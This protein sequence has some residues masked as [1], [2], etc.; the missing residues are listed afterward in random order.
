M[1]L[2]DFIKENN[3]DYSY[4]RVSESFIDELE[5]IVGFKIGEQ[6]KEYILNYGYLGYEH[7]ELF[8]VNNAQR[9]DSDLVKQTLFLNNKFDKAIGFFAIEDQGDGDYYLV[10]SND[11]VYRFILGSKT[12]IATNLK[13]NEYILNRF[14]NV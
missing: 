11:M 10:D 4:N 9:A 12:L 8:G 2:N 6:L 14:L 13:L 1:E 5:S 7:I 3:V